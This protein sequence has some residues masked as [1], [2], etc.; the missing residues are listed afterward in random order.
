M[1]TFATLL[2]FVWLFNVPASAALH[3][4]AGGG[5]HGGGGG[6]HV[7]VAHGHLGGGHFHGGH[8]VVYGGFGW[9]GYPYYYPYYWYPGY[10]YPDY[11][12]APDPV[13]QHYSPTGVSYEEL[14]KFWGSNLRQGRSSH[15][16]FVTFLRSNILTA[17][18]TGRNLF[19]NG[20]ARGYGKNAG[21]VFAR[22][23]DEAMPPPQPPAT[24]KP[25]EPIPPPVV[26]EQAP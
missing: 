13:G 25:L 15:D 7:S 20:F 4:S 6:G 18:E 3:G 12:P 17:S 24:S 21:P 14:G 10:A 1:K 11:G 8:A 9:W 2:P 22:A 16:Q 5:G 23:F 26:R 19:Q